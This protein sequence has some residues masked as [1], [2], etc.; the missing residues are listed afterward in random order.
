MNI[1]ATLQTSNLIRQSDS[2][3]KLPNYF[4]VIFSAYTVHICSAYLYTYIHT[5][6]C[7][8]ANTTYMHT[9]IIS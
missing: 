9:F 8:Y 4:P 1:G 2:L 6:V 3:P 7:N 5:C